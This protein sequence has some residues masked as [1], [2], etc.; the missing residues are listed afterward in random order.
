MLI[1]LIIVP[2]GMTKISFNTRHIIMLIYLLYVKL[3]YCSINCLITSAF[4]FFP[5]LST[6][7]MKHPIVNS[8]Y[9]PVTNNFS[10]RQPRSFRSEKVFASSITNLT[11]SSQR[12][13]IR[14]S[15]TRI[16][17]IYVVCITDL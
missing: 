15:N 7:R 5:F 13:H 16:A 17:H 2:V 14:I 8:L 3:K 9:T 11:S 4:P 10:Q 12:A 1:N 6:M